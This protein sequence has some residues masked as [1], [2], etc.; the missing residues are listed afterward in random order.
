MTEE[1]KV[2][3]YDRHRMTI[4]TN[5]KTKEETKP[6]WRKLYW[7]TGK[8][9]DEYKCGCVDIFQEYFPIIFKTLLKEDTQ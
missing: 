7:T 6:L 5:I 2:M 1:Q 8:N 4:H 3:L 9:S